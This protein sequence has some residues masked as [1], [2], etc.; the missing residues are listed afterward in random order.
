MIASRRSKSYH[1]RQDNYRGNGRNGSIKEGASKGKE[2]GAQKWQQKKINEGNF[3]IWDNSR[4]FVLDESA[5]YEETEEPKDKNYEGPIGT[6]LARRC[7]RPQVQ[8]TKAQLE[9]DKNRTGDGESAQGRTLGKNEASKNKGMKGRASKQAA[10]EEQFT[11]V[12]GY[13]GGSRVERTVITEEDEDVED[14][15]PPIEMTEHHQDPPRVDMLMDEECLHDAYRDMQV[16][17]S[18]EQAI[19]RA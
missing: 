5:N 10:E 3:K 17:G 8:I 12:R 14:L 19:L 9:N 6:K 13:E 18:G 2:G 4:F 7:K 11:V 1:T 15:L 16:D